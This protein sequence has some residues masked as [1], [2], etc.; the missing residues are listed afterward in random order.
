MGLGSVIK[1]GVNITKGLVPGHKDYLDFNG[2]GGGS[3]GPSREQ[4]LR[5]AADKVALNELLGGVGL[6]T[7]RAEERLAGAGTKA[8]EGDGMAYLAKLASRGGVGG[9]KA[10]YL[11]QLLALKNTETAAGVAKTSGTDDVARAYQT[12]GEQF[13]GV[14]G[15]GVDVNSP[16]LL[17]AVRRYTEG[18][19]SDTQRLLTNLTGQE[20]AQKNAILLQQIAPTLDETGALIESLKMLKEEQDAL[21]GAQMGSLIGGGIGALGG[22][23]LGGPAGS[24]AGYTAG[25]NIGAGIGGR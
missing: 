6:H 24:A 22:F 3:A 13:T 1:G 16:A 19:S 9:K 21:R 4:K 17:D 15:T 10:K 23:F 12:M 25:S 11:T 18:R 14:L 20:M 7:G 8:P 5:T 2:S